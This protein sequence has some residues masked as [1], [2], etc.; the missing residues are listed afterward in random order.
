MKPPVRIAV[1][2]PT[3]TDSAASPASLAMVDSTAS[4]DSWSAVTEVCTNR[5]SS[6]AGSASARVC[7]RPRSRT[8][9]MKIGA[10]LASPTA[11]NAPISSTADSLGADVIRRIASMASSRVVSPR[12]A[13]A[14]VRDCLDISLCPPATVEQLPDRSPNARWRWC[15][16]LHRQRSRPRRYPPAPSRST[17]R[18]A[19]PP[20]RPQP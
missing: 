11:S 1:I 3:M 19:A 2:R 7:R 6:D 15:R 18:W 5:M 13:L 16:G 8:A 9:S 17:A 4:T 10:L 14:S 12:G 20:R